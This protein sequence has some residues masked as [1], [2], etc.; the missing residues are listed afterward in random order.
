MRIISLLPS[1]TEILFALGLGD[2]LV[3]VSH[4]CDYPPE[5]RSKPV[6]S[7]SFLSK[8]K[9]SSETI[10]NTINQTYHRGKSIYHI[11]ADLLQRLDPDLIFTQ[12]LCEQCAVSYNEVREAAKILAGDRKIVSLEPKTLDDVLDNIKLIGEL[13]TTQA[14]AQQLVE[15]LSRR[16][17]VI[18][19]RAKTVEQ[20]PSVFCME[21]LN[22]PMFGGHWVPQMVDWAGGVDLWGKPGGKGERIDWNVVVQGRPE[23]VVAMPCSFTIERT[24]REMPR[25]AR[26]EGWSDLP[27]V[28]N[29]RVFVVDSPSYFSRHGPRLVTG[30]EILAQII[31]PEIFSGLIP[32]GAV[33]KLGSSGSVDEGEVDLPQ[34]FHWYR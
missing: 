30:L 11:N 26:F 3:G 29:G 6:I 10:H 32:D 16:I 23:I 24:L 19:S 25:V 28:K 15:S 31:H 4:E 5:V 22:P 17:H 1:S 33:K 21:W 27:A 12:E 13:T 8:D 20:R 2:R 18:R 9:D 7:S 14:K 34:R